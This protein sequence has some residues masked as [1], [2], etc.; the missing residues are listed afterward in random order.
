M[1]GACRLQATSQPSKR[2]TERSR[3][4]TGFLFPARSNICGSERGERGKENIIR[5]T[6]YTK[7]TSPPFFE[8]SPTNVI[9]NVRLKL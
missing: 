6:M 9:F 1:K 7:G 2:Q 8:V 5:R 3:A 4:F